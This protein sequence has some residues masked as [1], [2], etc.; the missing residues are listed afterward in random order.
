[1][2]KVWGE[3]PGSAIQPD[4]LLARPDCRSAGRALLGEEPQGHRVIA[5]GPGAHL[6]HP[7]LLWTQHPLEGEHDHMGDGMWLSSLRPLSDHVSI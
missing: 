1:M 6:V 4:H 3:T 5:P 2:D 7:V